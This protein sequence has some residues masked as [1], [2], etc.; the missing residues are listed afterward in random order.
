MARP[1]EI[2]TNQRPS[3]RTQVAKENDE[4]CAFWTDN[5]S[6]TV[7]H[8]NS[9]ASTAAGLAGDVYDSSGS[10]NFQADYRCTGSQ[11]DW[12][13]EAVPNF[14]AGIIFGHYRDHKPD[15]SVRSGSGVFPGNAI[16][17]S[18]VSNSAG[19]FGEM[20]DDS[21][22]IS[23]SPR[24]SNNVKTDSYCAT[25]RGEDWLDEVENPSC[26]SIFSEIRQVDAE[27]NLEPWSA[28]HVLRRAWLRPRT[29][30][31]DV[32]E[33]A[34]HAGG[35]RRNSDFHAAGPISGRNSHQDLDMRLS[36]RTSDS[37]D[38]PVP[39]LPCAKIIG[40]DGHCIEEAKK[41]WEYQPSLRSRSESDSIASIAFA[42]SG[43]HGPQIIG[44][45]PPPQRSDLSGESAINAT[46][47]PLYFQRAATVD[48]KMPRQNSEDWVFCQRRKH[49]LQKN[50]EVLAAIPQF[51]NHHA[52]P[53][54]QLGRLNPDA[55]EDTWP[56]PGSV[57]GT[58][59]HEPWLFEYGNA[60]PISPE[61]L[62]T[63]ISP[64]TKYNMP[65]HGI[66]WGVTTLMVRNI[67]GRYTLDML[68]KEWP[69][70][71]GAYDFLYLPMSIERKRNVSFC[72]LNFVTFN[73]AVNFAAK[74]QRR[75]LE[76]FRTRRPLDIS[77]ADLQG[78]E[79]NITQIL[80]AKVYRIRNVHFQPAIFV[81]P[82][83][84]TL[85]KYLENHNLKLAGAD[86]PV[87][88][89]PCWNAHRKP[90][91]VGLVSEFQNSF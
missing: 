44:T 11:A 89:W 21:V 39:S 68:L 87:M 52:D 91:K 33:S 48:P 83:R 20:F 77:A 7:G 9:D 40:I 31:T 8:V 74:W 73:D 25:F 78:R 51:E 56:N 43:C 17:S 15:E 37:M 30:W 81:G 61:I 84:V 10:E 6:H 90:L 62:G 12:P 46:D 2:H 72:F 50:L 29:V 36:W 14:D 76:H 13:D 82:V 60:P 79:E 67:P 28:E 45:E 35:S 18:S 42:N 70:T 71:D 58:N 1:K 85:E 23:F 69:N 5:I 88:S 80:T 4:T 65:H 66:P 24:G 19:V 63:G 3:F 34:F 38:T 75:R 54:H 27:T 55:V 22:R 64:T 26:C 41:T 49:Q 59:F 16:P 57:V 47:A 32:Q 86:I 53:I